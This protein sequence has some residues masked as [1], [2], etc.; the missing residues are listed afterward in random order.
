MSLYPLWKESQASQ[1][2]AEDSARLGSELAE[3]VR[4]HQDL[5]HRLSTATSLKDGYETTIRVLNT[6]LEVCM[7]LHCAWLDMI[8]T[9]LCCIEFDV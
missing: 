5:E 4:H 1:R 7:S 9:T 8:C 3:A 2:F 6:R